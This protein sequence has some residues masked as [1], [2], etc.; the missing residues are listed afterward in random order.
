MADDPTPTAPPANNG[1]KATRDFQL[2][3]GGTLGICMA[4]QGVLMWKLLGAQPPDSSWDLI[5]GL[6][7]H[8]GQVDLLLIGLIGG[9]LSRQS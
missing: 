3:V 1:V 2:M 9:R 4:L 7:Q 5:K 6:L 8:L